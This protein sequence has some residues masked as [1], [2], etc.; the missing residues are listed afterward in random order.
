MHFIFPAFPESSAPAR[1]SNVIRFH[2]CRLPHFVWE[3]PQ[4]SQEKRE[5]LYKK[6]LEYIACKESNYPSLPQNL[7]RIEPAKAVKAPKVSVIS[8]TIA[9]RG[10]T[11]GNPSYSHSSRKE[12]LNGKEGN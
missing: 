8:S 2:H 7:P 5:I 3:C 10:D 11:A 1:G 6:H 4:L 9:E 12:L